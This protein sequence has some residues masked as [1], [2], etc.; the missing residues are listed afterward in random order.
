MSTFVIWGET[1]EGSSHH[2]IVQRN[3]IEEAMDLIDARTGIDFVSLT[4]VDTD[5]S[6]FDEYRGIAELST[7]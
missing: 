5:P 3:S 2:Y 7:I 1:E 6:W 4:R